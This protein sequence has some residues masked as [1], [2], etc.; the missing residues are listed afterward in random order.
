VLPGGDVGG[1]G[2]EGESYSRRFVQWRPDLELWTVL[3]AY[4]YV[5]VE[6]NDDDEETDRFVQ[7]Q[8]EVIR[9]RD[10][11][12]PGGTEELADAGYIDYHG[13]LTEEAAAAMA[14]DYPTPTFAEWP[15]WTT[16]PVEDRE[17]QEWERRVA[18]EISGVLD[19]LTRAD[20]ELSAVRA[21]LNTLTGELYDIELVEGAA[22]ADAFAYL[23]DAERSLRSI[24]RIVGLRRLLLREGTDPR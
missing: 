18:A 24:R 5:F 16:P 14:R 13:E 3:T 20:R 15:Q 12:D 11:K 1:D 4:F 8:V 6:T 22:S 23:A 17:G 10:L 21:G 2:Q 7:C 19:R 9:C